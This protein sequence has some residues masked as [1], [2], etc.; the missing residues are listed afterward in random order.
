M[1]SGPGAQAAKDRQLTVL[2]CWDVV[3]MLVCC[4]LFMSYAVLCVFPKQFYL[5]CICLKDIFLVVLQRVKVVF[6]KLWRTMGF[7]VVSCQSDIS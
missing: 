3:F 7:S 5:C 2:H 6:G 1:A 4:S